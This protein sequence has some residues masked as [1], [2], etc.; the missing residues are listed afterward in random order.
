MRFVRTHRFLVYLAGA[1]VLVGGAGWIVLQAREAKRRADP[2]VAR[3]SGQPIPVRTAVVTEAPVEIVVGATA[4][5]IPSETAPIRVGVSRGL[6]SGTP[7]SDIVVKAVHVKDGDR[8]EKGQLL[9][10]LEDDLIRM[11]A[12]QREATLTTARAELERVGRANVLNVSIWNLA[13]T[14]AEA[15]VRFNTENLAIRRTESEALERLIS[16]TAASKFDCYEYRCKYVKARYDLAAAEVALQL[17]KNQMELGELSN[18]RDL[19]KATSDYEVARMDYET[20][21]HD[22]ER[23]QVKSPLDGFVIQENIAAG[24]AISLTGPLMQV[25]KLD[26]LRL[27]LD[28]PQ[29]R[30]SEVE[31]GQNAEIALD[32]FPQETFL[33]KVLVVPARVATDL[34]VAPVIVE[35]KNPGNRIKAGLSGYVRL[36]TTRKALTVPTPAVMQQGGRPTV[37]RVENERARLRPVRLGPLIEAGVQEVRGGLK[38][39]DEVVIYPANFYKHYGDLTNLNAYLQDNDLVNV[40]WKEWARRD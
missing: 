6:S 23:C 30:L 31:V 25:I 15:N 5:T 2:A 32:S 21:Q 37:F 3:R 14:S 38:A 18:R 9:F 8:V 33:G 13:L 35:M 1:A 10:E 16:A 12:Q 20:A 19:A 4:V 17:A 27:R 36:R 22:V 11:F 40:T 7:I 29:E 24:T 26:P 39:G 34:R 28:C